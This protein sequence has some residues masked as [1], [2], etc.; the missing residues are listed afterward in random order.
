M[1]T[2][3]EAIVIPRFG[4]PEVLE[5]QHVPKPEPAGGEVLVKVQAFGLNHAEMHMRKGGEFPNGSKVIGVMGGMGRDRP[6]SYGEYVN[7]PASN[8][9][10]IETNLPW[11]ELAAIPEVYSC[12]YSCVF[13]VLDVKHGE[14]LLIRGATSTIGQAAVK[15]AVNAGAN[16][17][18]TTR[19]KE[20]FDMMRGM[21][22]ED[23]RVENDGLANELPGTRFD[24]VLNLIGNRVLVESISLTRVG[25]RMLQ[26]GWLGG[27]APVK[28]F[29][30][31]VEMESGVH[32]SL[33]HS[34][35]VGSPSFPLSA[36]PLQDIVRKI[37]NGAWDAKPTYVFDW[38]D[39]RKAHEM[40]D[41]HNAGGKIVIKH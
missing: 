37:E 3:M 32:F 18:A 31:M 23:V 40:L 11:E 36:I 19:R 9:A 30:P 28:D 34:K 5:Y 21:G 24:K 39:V 17:T 20:R 12:A 10:R 25:G 16:V 38:K 33:F 6:G 22:V 13:T 26:A 27:L 35:V 29:N 15:L 8:V 1:S 4:G 7:V 14:S 2:M 41:S